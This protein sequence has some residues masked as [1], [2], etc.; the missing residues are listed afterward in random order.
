MGLEKER[1]VTIIKNYQIVHHAYVD[2]IGLVKSLPEWFNS[3]RYYFYEKGLSEKDVG[4]GHEVQ[5]AWIASRQAT[6]YLKF[7]VEVM[8]LARDLRKVVLEDGEE[9]YWS[10]LLVVINA[11]MVKDWQGKYKPYGIQDVYR[12]FYERFLVQNEIRKYGDELAREV[13]ELIARLK[14]FLQ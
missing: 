9:T 3:Y 4:T 6:D 10:R 7:E 5:S 8:I 2:F 11:Q 13:V 1:V 12:Q 14:T